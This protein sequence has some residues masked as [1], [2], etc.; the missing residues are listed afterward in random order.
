MFIQTA[1]IKKQLKT[2]FLFQEQLEYRNNSH[3]SLYERYSS[4]IFAITRN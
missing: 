2:R 1:A 4:G 3:V